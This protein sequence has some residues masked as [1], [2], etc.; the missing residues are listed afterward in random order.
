MTKVVRDPRDVLV[1][2]RLMDTITPYL[3]V[4]SKSYRI[5]VWGRGCFGF[6]RDPETHIIT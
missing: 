3:S 6:F 5:V 4:T 1:R 2:R